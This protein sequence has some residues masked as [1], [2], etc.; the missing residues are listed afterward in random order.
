[1]MLS[2]Q[3][4]V[5]DDDG[6]NDNHCSIYEAPAPVSSANKDLPKGSGT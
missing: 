5:D 2:T 1:M 3:L 4:D 6:G